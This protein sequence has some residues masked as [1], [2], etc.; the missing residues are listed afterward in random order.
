MPRPRKDITDA[1]LKEIETLAGYGLTNAQIA[2][3]LGMAPRTFRDKKQETRVSAALLKGK[4]VAE[5]QIGEA[6]FTLAKGGNLGAIIWWEKTRAGRKEPQVQ[7]S[8]QITHEERLKL[9]G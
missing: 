4:A 5:R 1:Q 9:L 2:N 7:V 8:S 6:L 3:V